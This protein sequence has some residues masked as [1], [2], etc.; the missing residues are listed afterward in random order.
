MGWWLSIKHLKGQ[1][2]IDIL[3]KLEVIL[4]RNDFEDFCTKMW[5]VWRDRCTLNHKTSSNNKH[6]PV[7]DMGRWT[8]N[9][10]HE[11]RKANQKTL[12]TGPSMVER[13]SLPRDGSGNHHIS[14]FV[15]AAYCDTALKYATGFTIFDPGG[16]LI[17]MGH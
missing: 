4:S 2:T 12:A 6:N 17:A 15:D 3:H 13:L 11:F 9:L 14:I 16:K 8:N 7:S 1:A 10:L 5:G